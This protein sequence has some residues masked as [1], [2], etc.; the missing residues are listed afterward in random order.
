MIQLKSPR[1]I[2]A[3]RQSGAIIAGMHHMLRDLIE[4]GID[5]WEIE[6]KSEYIESHGGVPLQI[7]FEGFKY[8]TTISINDEVAHG[9]PRKGLKLKNGDLVK[10]DTVVGLNGAVSDSAWS[11]AVGEVTPE[12]QKLMD[13]TKKAMYLGIDQRLLGIALVMWKCH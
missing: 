11:Y 6:T 9:L 12:V 10:V 8:A 3:M 4:P 7:G 13:V 5:T 2:E 1:E